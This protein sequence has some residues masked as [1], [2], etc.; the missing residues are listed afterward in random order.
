M[1]IIAFPKVEEADEHG[2]LAVGGDLEVSSL[3]LAY[4]QG[5]FPWPISEQLPLC[6]FSPDPRGILTF[7]DLT[8]NR[9]LQKFLKNRSSKYSV[10]F[11]TQFET[12]IRNCAEIKR[13]NQNSTWITEDIIEAYI[14][15]FYYGHAYSVEVTNLET[16]ALVGGVYGVAINGFFSGE[17][18]FSKEDNVSKLAL[19]ALLTKLNDF[20][21]GWLD[22]QMITPVVQSLGGKLISRN[23][24]M[25][26][27]SVSLEKKQ[28]NRKL[29]FGN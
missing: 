3:L 14:D 10:T 9:T 15:L 7:K 16:Q 29:I 26:K 8:I 24:F 11:N 13:A 22:T 1:A 20:N 17:S 21:I 27:L 2:L 19:I 25:S 4:Q 23:K 18:M 5:I 28:L 6:W 12:V